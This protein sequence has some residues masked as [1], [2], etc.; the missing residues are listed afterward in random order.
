MAGGFD[1]SNILTSVLT[2]LPGAEDWTDLASLPRPLGGARASIVGGRL[3]MTGGWDGD[4]FYISEVMA[5]E[6]VV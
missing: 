2:L 4:G 6:I 1:G 5:R 3:R